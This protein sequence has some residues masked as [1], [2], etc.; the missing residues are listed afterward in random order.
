MN[1]LLEIDL[2]ELGL[3]DKYHI[4]VKYLFNIDKCNLFE[5]SAD[6]SYRM[7]NEISK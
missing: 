5:N 6:E 1:L 3:A 2:I 7:I 4:K